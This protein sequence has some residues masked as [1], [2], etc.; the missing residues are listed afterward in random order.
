MQADVILNEPPH[1]CLPQGGRA[2][3]PPP[4]Y[5]LEINKLCVQF[6]N[7]LTLYKENLQHFTNYGY[8]DKLFW[9][10]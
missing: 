4:L 7:C 5:A 1:V 6:S 9:V 8:Q 2:P 3:Q 10:V